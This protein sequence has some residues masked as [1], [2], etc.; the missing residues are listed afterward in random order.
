MKNCYS[1]E[2]LYDFLQELKE[3]GINLNTV[4][5]IAETNDLVCKDEAYF[6]PGVEFRQLP[7][8]SD[9]GMTWDAEDQLVIAV[10]PR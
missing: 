6:Q 8:G 5:V 1:A 10:G 3:K 9:R 2:M 7:A 4:V